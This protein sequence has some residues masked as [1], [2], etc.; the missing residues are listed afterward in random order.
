MFFLFLP[1]FGYCQRYDL[2]DPVN[3][4]R[5]RHYVELFLKTDESESLSTDKL[6]LFLKTLDEKKSSF[7]SRKDFFGYL[8]SKTHKRFL[9]HYTDYCNFSALLNK[10]VYNCLT[11][12]ALYGLI[13]NHFNVPYKIIETNYHIFLT[14]D[15]PSGVILF[16]ATDP[17][18]GFVTSSDE[19]E[20]RINKYKE[21]QPSNGNDDRMFYRYNFNFYNTIDL[22]QLVGLMYYNLS[23]DAYN[24]KR[25]SAS[26]TSLE[27]AAQLY[28]T[29]RTDEF[30]K[31][32][33]LTLAEGRINNAEKEVCLK[34]LQALRK[35]GL[36]LA[37]NAGTN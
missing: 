18:N 10:G 17:I 30:S 34:E 35:K 23:V 32:I 1:L 9:K 2:P 27:K 11:G 4:D 12:T 28:K 8:F 16:E 31:I 29:Q 22:H 21:I 24:N 6:S 13:L 36:F 5:T 33:M 14:I 37:S 20:A 7:K 19:I 3:E 26:I 15:D 25:F